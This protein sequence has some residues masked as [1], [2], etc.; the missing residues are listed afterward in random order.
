ME[1]KNADLT[2]SR[3]QFVMA[4]A[5]R[6]AE[7]AFGSGSAGRLVTVLVPT[8]KSG[9]LMLDADLALSDEGQ[10]AVFD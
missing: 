2:F 5:R 8:S 6:P 9:K 3:F 10:L 7:L 4:R 1:L